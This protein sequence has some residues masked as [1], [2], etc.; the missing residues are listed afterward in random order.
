MHRENA[1]YYCWQSTKTEHH[2]QYLGSPH[3]IV[4]LLYFAL[5]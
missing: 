4:V 2:S 1:E 5:S 3:S